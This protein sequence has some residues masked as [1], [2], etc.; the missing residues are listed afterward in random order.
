MR[1][2]IAGATG[3]IGSRLVPFLTAAGHD[4]V[5]LARS[6]DRAAPGTEFVVADALDRESLTR[7]VQDAAPDA[8]V[9]M[10][11]AIP[12]EIDS[13]RLARDFALTNRLRTEGTRNLTD[14][15]KQAGARR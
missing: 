1:V 8:V 10:L 14:A 7:A 15:A 13:K 5:G 4:V 12:S 11:T 9:N 2:L 6:R 3:V